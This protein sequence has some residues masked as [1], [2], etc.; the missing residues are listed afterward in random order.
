MQYITAITASPN[1]ALWQVEL[2][3]VKSNFIWLGAPSLELYTLCF[4]S[5]WT[6]IFHSCSRAEIVQPYKSSIIFVKYLFTT[7]KWAIL[8]FICYSWTRESM[9]A[10]SFTYLIIEVV[11]VDVILVYDKFEIDTYSV[12]MYRF[13]FSGFVICLFIVWQSYISANSMEWLLLHIAVAMV[14][15]WHSGNNS[16]MLW[17]HLDDV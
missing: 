11:F 2:S 14:G 5:F 7:S 17:D 4:E 15:I 13:E 3:S 6:T 10:R 9:S 8:L 12:H 1:N 16:L